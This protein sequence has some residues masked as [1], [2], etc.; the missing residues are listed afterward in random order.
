MQQI[1]YDMKPEEACA[2]LGVSLMTLH[3]WRHAGRVSEPVRQGRQTL[4]NRYEIE[5]LAT[6]IAGMKHRQAA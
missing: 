2:L 5:A 3:R 6:G 1:E 4:F